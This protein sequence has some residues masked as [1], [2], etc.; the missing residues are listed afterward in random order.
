MVILRLVARGVRAD[1][2]AMKNFWTR[3]WIQSRWLWLVGFALL[4]IAIFW[5]LHGLILRGYGDFE[6]FYT[7][8]RIVRAGQA[9]QLYD[10]ALQWKIQQEFASTVEIRKGPLPFVRPPFQALLFLPFAYLSYPVACSI[11]SA[12]NLATLLLFPLLLPR[13]DDT[14]F[15]GSTLALEIVSCLAFFPAAFCLIQGQD[16]I[17]LL[18]ILVL[19]LRLLLRGAEI[20]CG[21]VLGLGLFK[22][23]LV[24]PLIAVFALR[25]KFKVVAGFVGTAAVLLAISLMMVHWSGLVNYP[26][27]LLHMNEVPGMGMG[28]AMSMPNPRGVLEILL[29]TWHFPVYAHLIFG[30]VVCLGILVATC[31]WPGTDRRSITAAF[32]S[33]IAITLASAYYSNSYDLTLLLLPLMLFVNRFWNWFEFSGWRRR[34]FLGATLLLFCTPLL[35]ILAQ[36]VDRF[37]WTESIVLA[38]AVSISVTGRISTAEPKVGESGKI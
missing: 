8:G 33:W 26:R 21:I 1:S 13:F 4:N 29:R 19:G 32:C 34:L 37:G 35:W 11:W 28:K 31:S 22:F 25:R 16:A 5:R 36:P 6:S 14:H 15:S 2:G 3:Y 20:E 38:Y 23:H 18:L 12:L 30:A 9:D 10:R 7:A 24:L 17:L 27:Y